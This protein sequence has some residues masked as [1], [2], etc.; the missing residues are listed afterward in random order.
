MEDPASVA[1]PLPD[2][3][4]TP[5]NVPA[6]YLQCL[7][8][9]G[10]KASGCH[11]GEFSEL[12]KYPNTAKSQ[13]YC[14]FKNTDFGL[15]QPSVRT[16]GAQLEHLSL[17]ANLALTDDVEMS[18]GFSTYQP[19]EQAA[20]IEHRWR[21]PPQSLVR[22]TW[23]TLQIHFDSSLRKL[24]A[25]GQS[26]LVSRFSAMSALDVVDRGIATS[27]EI[28]ADSK[29]HSPV[30]LICLIHLSYAMSLAVYP[31]E[32]RESSREF[33]VQAMSYN[34]WVE[35]CDRQAYINMVD[36]LWRPN[37]MPLTEVVGLLQGNA[38][39]LNGLDTS[40]SS[41]PVAPCGSRRSDPILN[42]VVLVLDGKYQPK[43]R[44]PV[45]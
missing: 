13:D 44:G 4:P 20:H 10:L 7:L 6:T 3:L 15:Y 42:V 5:K 21:P 38:W 12:E 34:E 9:G 16:E 35:R 28:M 45:G 19:Q 22:E 30:N 11:G 41:N 23:P 26:P 14:A 31:G 32:Y 18:F 27:L 1:S 8:S 25:I 36:A 37:D 40:S 39:T 2:E 24:G 17:D 43:V 33:F 29:C